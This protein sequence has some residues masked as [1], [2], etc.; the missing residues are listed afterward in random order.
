MGCRLGGGL[1]HRQGLVRAR[2]WS[3]AFDSSRSGWSFISASLFSSG[4]WLRR[5]ACLPK[6]AELKAEQTSNPT[7]SARTRFRINH[8]VATR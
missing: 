5:W 4:I 1:D 8:S 7:P 6:S 2:E 3:P